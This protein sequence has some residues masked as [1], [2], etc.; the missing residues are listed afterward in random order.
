MAA[1]IFLISVISVE[2]RLP[3]AW[4]S[5][6]PRQDLNRSVVQIPSSVAVKAGGQ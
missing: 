2:L 6:S 5:P 4:D 1:L 3:G